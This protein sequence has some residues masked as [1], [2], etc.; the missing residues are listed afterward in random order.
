MANGIRCAERTAR[1]KRRRD[2]F[3]TGSRWRG[4]E[5]ETDMWGPHVSEGR[6]RRRRRWKARFKEESVFRRI[7][8]RRARGLSG[9][10]AGEARRLGPA[11]RP[12]PGG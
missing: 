6:E 4:E 8:H 2:E 12:R 9:Q 7:R 5:D 11:G 10:W 3:S 1:G